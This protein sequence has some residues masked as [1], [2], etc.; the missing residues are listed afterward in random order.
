[1]GEKKI[2]FAMYLTSE[3]IGHECGASVKYS[4]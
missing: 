3:K 4:I 2:E 1:M